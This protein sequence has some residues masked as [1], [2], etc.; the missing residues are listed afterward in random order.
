MS[1]FDRL[2]G[3][4]PSE[5]GAARPPQDPDQQ[6]IER[7]RYMLRTAPPEDIEGAHAEAFAQLTPEQRAKVLTSLSEYV[8]ASERPATDDPASLARAATR[9]E[10]RQPGTLE[11]A[12]QGP[13]LG[14]T[15]L[16]TLAGVFVGTAIAD[17]FFGGPGGYGEGS[18]EGETDG[19]GADGDQA[20][21]AGDAD[22]G[23]DFGGGDFGSGD[24]G[25]GDFGGGDFGGI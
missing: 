17:A 9:A 6:A 22:T 18:Q 19:S 2:M 5:Q 24:F 21:D 14:S 11:R 13:G 25:G 4:P 23:G 7:Y 10:M 16:T 20:G 15:F 12:W 3:R 8:P 1:F